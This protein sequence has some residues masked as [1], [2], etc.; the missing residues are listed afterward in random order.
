MQWAQSQYK[1]YF[2][3][4]ILELD[5]FCL[6]TVWSF[7]VSIVYMLPERVWM[8]IPWIWKELFSLFSN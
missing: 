4:I 3:D 8:L 7:S 1:Q 6:S 2:L 5:L